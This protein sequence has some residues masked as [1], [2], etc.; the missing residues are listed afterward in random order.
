MSTI[1][2]VELPPGIG[3]NI[4]LGQLP[5]ILP[6]SRS[7]LDVHERVDPVV[8]TFTRNGEFLMNFAVTRRELGSLDET[9]VGFLQMVVEAADSSSSPDDRP[10][11]RLVP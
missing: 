2:T 6:G 10:G 8:I 3:I 7:V 5:D 11:P 9:L 1:G 4:Y